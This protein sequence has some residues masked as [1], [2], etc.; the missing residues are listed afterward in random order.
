LFLTGL[1]GLTQRFINNILSCEMK[2]APSPKKISLKK[3]F[4]ILFGVLILIVVIA[5]GIFFYQY[6]K[7]QELLKNPQKAKAS[8]VQD[9]VAKVGKLIKLPN[10]TPS[11]ATISDITKLANQSIFRNAQNGDK[12]LIFNQSK[13]AIVYRPSEN[14]IVE[15]GNL[16]IKD[17]GTVSGQILQNPQT[18]PQV[19]KVSVYNGTK[20]AGLAKSE[21]TSLKSK[22]PNVEVLDTKN[23][24]GEYQKTLIIDLTGRNKDFAKILAS[25]LG[26]EVGILPKDE[27]KPSSDI[28]IILGK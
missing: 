23:A 2:E 7:N 15:V 17:Q 1:T 25:D 24:T 28:L 21:A 6:Q 18:T 9:V 26:G 11:V 8:E 4:F 3:P 12:V 5:G 13:R 14:Q 20:T 27:E 19:I 10:E 22:Y 16:V